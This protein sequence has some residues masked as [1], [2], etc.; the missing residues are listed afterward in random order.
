MYK[1]QR[2]GWAF[3]ETFKLVRP[4][5]RETNQLETS[6]ES[7]TTGLCIKG[8]KIDVLL[9]E[10]IVE[11]LVDTGAGINIIDYDLVNSKLSRDLYTSI[12]YQ[13]QYVLNANGGRMNICDCIQLRFVIDEKCYIDNFFVI[14]NIGQPLILGMPFLSKYNV[15]LCLGK[16]SNQNKKP[17]LSYDLIELPPRHQGIY[18]VSV[19]NK[20]HCQR[21]IKIHQTGVIKSVRTI[22]NKGIYMA[23]VLENNFNGKQMH[24]LLLNTTDECITILPRTKLAYFE[25]LNECQFSHMGNLK[26]IKTNDCLVESPY[27]VHHVNLVSPNE[28]NELNASYL[29]QKLLNE[30][31]LCQNLSS[32]QIKQ[33][34]DVIKNH[35]SAF[36]LDGKLGRFDRVKHHIDDQGHTPA[37]SRP[38]RLSPPV[39]ASLREQIENLLS[40]GAIEESVSPYASPV[41]MV[42]KKDGSY[43]FCVD[44]RNLNRNTVRDMFPLPVD[45]DTFH[46]VGMN[47]PSY[48][49]KLDLTSG[50]WQIELD[51]ESKEKTAFITPNG[52]Y[53]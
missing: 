13:L 39:Q 50:F 6:N 28:H 46:N 30:V 5:H 22:K 9:G 53:Q 49:S 21:H 38:Y 40:Q 48:F 52:L 35:S 36:S 15:N 2:Q 44:F 47:S 51:E 41:V 31:Q 17:V 33:L 3:F 16:Q 42:R 29:E 34:R 11:T 14:Q 45:V 37:R 10:Y 20:G 23:N 43:R 8:N 7:E 19:P 12:S 18:R 27:E 32:V 26:H 4:S 24:V 1:C 25:I